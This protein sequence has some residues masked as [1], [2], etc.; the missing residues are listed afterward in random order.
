MRVLYSYT[1]QDQ[2]N[3]RLALSYLKQHTHCQERVFGSKAKI[4]EAAFTHLLGYDGH[5]RGDK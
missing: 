1:E 3:P 2:G 4:S 5:K